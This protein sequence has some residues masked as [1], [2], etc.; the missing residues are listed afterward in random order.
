MA[1]GEKRLKWESMQHVGGAAT[2]V[3]GLG[4]REGKQHVGGAATLV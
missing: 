1:H 3:S 4:F 2:L